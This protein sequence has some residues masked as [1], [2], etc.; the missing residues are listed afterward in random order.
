MTPTNNNNN[1]NGGGGHG[2]SNIHGFSIRYHAK[3]IRP[4]V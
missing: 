3:E 2:D 4:C 1:N